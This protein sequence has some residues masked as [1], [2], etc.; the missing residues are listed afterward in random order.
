MYVYVKFSI[1]FI[2]KVCYNLLLVEIIY[3]IKK[4]MK[5]LGLLIIICILIYI[6]MICYRNIFIYFSYIVR[7]LGIND[8]YLY[9]ED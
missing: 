7:K 6:G 4:N 2:V 8:F 9:R 3:Y 5:I 1:N